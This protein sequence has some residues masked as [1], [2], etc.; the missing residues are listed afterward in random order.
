MVGIGDRCDKVNRS[1]GFGEF[2]GITQKVDQDPLHML[3]VHHDIL[4]VAVLGPCPVRKTRVCGLLPDD[5][6][7][8]LNDPRLPDRC[9][10]GNDLAGVD[11]AGLQNFI[12][13]AEQI[14]AGRLDLLQIFLELRSQFSLL[15]AQ[16]HQPYDRRH[17][18]P[19]VV[20]HMGQER[21]LLS[22][23]LYCHAQCFGHLLDL[24]PVIDLFGGI[25]KREDQ[26]VHILFTV[27]DDVSEMS[28]ERVA[29]LLFI[30][31]QLLIR[32]NPHKI[33]LACNGRAVL[34]DR[35]HRRKNLPAE[36]DQVDGRE[37]KGY[38]AKRPAHILI[39]HMEF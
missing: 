37:I 32:R 31:F 13:Q 38:I 1:A 24:L 21:F 34:L 12:D 6:I 25:Y 20:A 33:G 4:V 29:F 7:H 11:A 9:A 10:D 8:F 17:G 3:R 16:L 22:A 2:D 5:R 30:L 27:Q 23:C 15:Q 39:G 18:G 28:V 19:H 14:S 35:F 26:A 36:R